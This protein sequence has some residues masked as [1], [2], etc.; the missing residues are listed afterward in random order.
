MARSYAQL[1][2]I[3]FCIVGVGGFLTGDAG[4]L[5]N[6]HASGNFDG[7]ALHMTYVRDVIDLLLA[8][9]FVYAG[10]FADR[11]AGLR[12]VLGTGAFLLLLA[13]VGFA[14]GET[15][16]GSRSIAGLHFTL[17][18]NIFDLIAGTLAVL[19]AFGRL[20]EAAPTAAR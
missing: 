3:V 11:V 14:V 17:A 12:T 1:A 5:V 4:T 13:I 10:F 9:A 20:D 6:G 18:I 2:A 15:E 7:V 8:G 16:T 19:C